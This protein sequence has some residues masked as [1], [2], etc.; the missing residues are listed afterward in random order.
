MLRG[1]GSFCV[2]RRKHFR[3]AMLTA[4][5]PALLLAAT[6]AWAAAPESSG[7]VSLQFTIPVPVAST[8]KTGGMYGFDIS[9]VELDDANLLSRRPL[10]R[11]G[12]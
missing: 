12:R 6:A 8:N 4:A 5:A 1:E 10:E 3:L 2:I 9:F 7:P 11:L